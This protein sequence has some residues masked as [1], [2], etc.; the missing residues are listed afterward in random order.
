[1]TVSITQAVANAIATAI[2]AQSTGTATNKLHLKNAAGTTIASATDVDVTVSTNVLSIASAGGLSVSATDTAAQFQLTTAGDVE[3]IAGLNQTLTVTVANQ[4]AANDTFT[5]TSHGLEKGQA[6]TIGGG[7]PTTNPAISTGDTVYA[8][9]VTTNTFK[10]ERYR[11]AGAVD[12]TAAAGTD[13]TFQTQVAVGATN[14][15]A[16]LELTSVAL[17]SGDTIAIGSFTFTVPLKLVAS[18][19]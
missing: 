14:S 10:I 15:G 5:L 13:T 8:T 17:T 2:D 1:M 12:I 19:Q 9:E 18:N 3:L 7:I 16:F 4:S 11:G 6:L